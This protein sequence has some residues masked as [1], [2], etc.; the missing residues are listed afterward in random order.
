MSDNT[1]RI[2]VKMMTFIIGTP[3]YSPGQVVDLEP[4]V[5]QAWIAEG[6][7]KAVTSDEARA[8]ARQSQGQ[9]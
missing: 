7:C 6:Y 4:R 3:S 8:A 5:A 2:T 1:K 9:A